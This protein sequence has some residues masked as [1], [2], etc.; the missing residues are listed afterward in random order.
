MPPSRRTSRRPSATRCCCAWSGAQIEARDDL[1]EMFSKRI[2]LFYTQAQQER[3]LIRARH[4]ALTEEL[5]D[6]FVDVL[7]VM[8]PTH[9][10][11]Y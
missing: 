8:D 7:R 2:A 9:P 4:R 6:T 5:I 3:E 10:M 1:V 11:H